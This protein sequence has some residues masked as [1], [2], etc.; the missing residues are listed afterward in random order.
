M[1]V[2]MRSPPSEMAATTNITRLLVI[3]KEPNERKESEKK[4]R[5]NEKLSRASAVHSHAW[6]GR[7]VAAQ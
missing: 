5:K 1:T 4:R 3:H 6:V 7:I 2:G